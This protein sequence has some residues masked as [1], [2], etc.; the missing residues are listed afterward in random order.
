MSSDQLKLTGKLADIMLPP[1]DSASPSATEVHVPEF[2]E[3]WISALY[4]DNQ[5]DS[6]SVLNGLS[7]MD[8]ESNRRFSDTFV[9]LSTAEAGKICND[10]CHQ[11]KASP[12][13]LVGAG[14][15]AAGGQ[16]AKTSNPTPDEKNHCFP[17]Y[18]DLLGFLGRS[19]AQRHCDHL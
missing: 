13:H 10:I 1:M 2:I 18:I 6:K 15:G 12:D 8:E 4:P 3:E 11:A 14:S 5:R 19:Q 7:W 9:G 17:R 16:S